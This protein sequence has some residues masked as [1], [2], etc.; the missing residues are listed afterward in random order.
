MAATIGHQ[1]KLGAGTTGMTATEEY[2][3]VSGDIVKTGTHLQSDGTRGTRA[4]ISE[5]VVEGQYTVG[6]TVVLNLSA[7]DWAA[8]FPRLIGAGPTW[9]ETIPEFR[10]SRYRVAKSHHY[11]GCKVNRWTIRSSAAQQKVTLEM[12]IQGKTETENTSYP[13]LTIN[14]VQ[15]YVHSELVLTLGGT[16]YA[17]DELVVTG[18]NFLLLD[19]FRNSQ[20][21]SELPEGDCEISVSAL[22]PYTSTE[23]GLYGDSVTGLAATAVWTKGNRSMSLSFGIL[24]APDESPPFAGR[25]NE[26]KLRLNYMARKTGSTAPIVVTIDTTP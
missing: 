7:V 25:R 2:E 15:P 6:G 21:R 5:N 3:L 20:T 10:V 24:Q 14:T 17:C 9:A 16:A 18:N 4:H 19:L 22:L 23:A 1:E 26:N 13:A 8:W 12:D 11:D